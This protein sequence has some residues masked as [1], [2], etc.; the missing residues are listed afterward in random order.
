MKIDGTKIIEECN[1]Q[2]GPFSST[3]NAIPSLFNEKSDKFTPNVIPAAIDSI[4]SA[5]DEQEK[6]VWNINNSVVN[7]NINISSF[8]PYSSSV[9]ND[10]MKIDAEIAIQKKENHEE[11]TE[12]KHNTEVKSGIQ[13]D[14]K[15]VETATTLK[16]KLTVQEQKRNAQEWAIKE[17]GVNFGKNKNKK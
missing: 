7:F 3:I 11:K 9:N 1:E 10:K 4:L 15:P 17:F 2:M 16:R 13:N 6:T 5:I 12:I 8:N 14:E